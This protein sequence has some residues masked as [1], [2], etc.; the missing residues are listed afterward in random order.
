MLALPE[1]ASAA[2]FRETAAPDAF[3]HGEPSYVRWA[4]K[5]H[6]AP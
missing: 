1:V 2:L 4:P 5:I 3:L 6:R